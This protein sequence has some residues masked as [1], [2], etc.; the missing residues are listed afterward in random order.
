[1]KIIV[2]MDSIRPRILSEIVKSDQVRHC[3]NSADIFSAN[4]H[5]QDP[6]QFTAKQT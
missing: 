1:M 4:T 2:Q 6:S 5:S 3:S